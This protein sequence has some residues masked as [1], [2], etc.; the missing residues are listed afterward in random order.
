[1]L[2]EIVARLK[3]GSIKD[4]VTFGAKLPGRDRYVVVKP[5]AMPDGTRGVRVIAHFPAGQMETMEGYVLGELSGL[6]KGHRFTDAVGNVNVVY[7][8]G[9]W[10][11]YAVTSDDGTVSME[12]LFYVPMRA[13]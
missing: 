7:D 4:V 8:S 12:R 13:H 3:T 2:P 11:D 1:M 9:E 5:E 6:L 10:T